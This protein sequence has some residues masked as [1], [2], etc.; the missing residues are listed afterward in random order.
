V[1]K[2]PINNLLFADPF[3]IAVHGWEARVNKA[4]FCANLRLEI[5]GIL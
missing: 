4:A 5:F 3:A 1:V 2:A